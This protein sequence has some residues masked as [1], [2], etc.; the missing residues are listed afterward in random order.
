VASAGLSTTPSNQ[1]GAEGPTGLFGAVLRAV[2]SAD[3]VR[4]EESPAF[5]V[6]DVDQARQ[7][8]TRAD[9]FV[10]PFSVRRGRVRRRGRAALSRAASK[11]TQAL[12]PEAVQAGRTAFAAGLR[13]AGAGLSEPGGADVDALD[14]LRLPVSRSTVAALVPEAD[15]AA[16]TPVGDK[17]LAWVDSLAP[18]ISAARPPRRWTAVRRA[19]KSA[20][21][22]LVQALSA[23]R[24][25]DPASLGTALAA[26]V[27]VPIAAGAWCLTLLAADPRRQDSLRDAPELVLPFVWEVVRLYPPTWLLPRVTTREVRLGSTT[28][29][30]YTPVLVSPLALGRLPQLVPGP[31]RHFEDLDALDP[32]RW[33]GDVRPGA[34]LPFGAG[35]HACPGR[36]LGLAM[37]CELVSWAADFDLTSQRPPVPDTS[38]GLAPVPSWIRLT[39]R[40]EHP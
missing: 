30:P 12:S 9:D 34:W 15:D 40:P 31:S 36:N 6:P 23:L 7:V 26:G 19:E 22:A 28:L 27:Q 32:V 3:P 10:I 18:I 4:L 13:E 8:L 35:P 39:P 25:H 24:V 5:L 2:G 37:M 21:D 11:E 29:A 33:T 38:R 14:L 20:L 16:R 17:V 1:D